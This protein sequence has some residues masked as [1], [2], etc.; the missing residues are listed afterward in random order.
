MG[1]SPGLSPF[2][3]SPILE[4]P[5]YMPEDKDFQL[6]TRLTNTRGFFPYVAAALAIAGII[7][8]IA[9]MT[10]GVG[11]RLLPMDDAYDALTAPAAEDGSEALALQ[12]LEQEVTDKLV[13]IRGT[14]FNRT[15]YPISMLQAVIELRDTYGLPAQSVPVGVEPDDMPA[16]STAMFQAVIVPEKKIGSYTIRFRLPDDGPFVAHK[17][18]RPDAAPTETKPN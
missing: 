3:I 1:N 7:G 10:T 13:S 12:T 8:I 18:E 15:A 14:V 4:Y 5:S 2:S 9:T 11:A 17:D 16:Q 6:E